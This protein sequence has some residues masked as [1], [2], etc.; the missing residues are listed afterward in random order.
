MNADFKVNGKVIE[1]SRIILRPFNITDLNDFFEYACVPFVGEKAGWKHH[2]NIED[3]LKILNLFISEDKTF[4]IVSKENNKVIGSIGVEFYKNIEGYNNLDSLKGRELGF[5]LSKNYWGQGIMKEALE[6]LIEYLFNELEFDFL[7]CS[8]F[9]DNI[10]S[11]RVQEKVGLK[12]L[13]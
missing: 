10:Q 12:E 7:I 11:I 1:T 9:L 6:S 3:S 2:E 13:H 5:V 4:A 8:H